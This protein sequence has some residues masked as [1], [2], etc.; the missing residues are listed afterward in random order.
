MAFG[1]RSRVVSEPFLTS[2]DVT[3]LRLSCV[4][5]TLL[6]GRRAAAYDVPPRATKS[7][8]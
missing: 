6:A 8:R 5:P 3:A 2:D 7:A 1:L 4:R